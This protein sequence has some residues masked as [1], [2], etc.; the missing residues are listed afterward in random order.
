V[1]VYT[2]LNPN[3]FPSEKGRFDGVYPALLKIGCSQI[4]F[5]PDTIKGSLTPK[6]KRI[7]GRSMSRIGTDKRAACWETPR[8]G[9]VKIEV[10][11]PTYRD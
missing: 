3:N 2:H 7:P 1:K 10:G 9:A 4:A 8:G 5:S 6:P 11:M